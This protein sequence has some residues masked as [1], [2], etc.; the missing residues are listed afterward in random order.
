MPEIYFNSETGPSDD[1]TKAY[2]CVVQTAKSLKKFD[3][4]VNAG[5]FMADAFSGIRAFPIFRDTSGSTEY[6]YDI[7]QK[8]KGED[9]GFLSYLVS[10]LI[11]YKQFSPD[12]KSDWKIESLGTSKMY[13]RK[14]YCCY[15]VE[16]YR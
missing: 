9:K 8:A 5:L 6:L 16:N 3:E 2:S 11:K 1:K 12:V 7:L 4:K 14:A 15:S 10:R 13:V